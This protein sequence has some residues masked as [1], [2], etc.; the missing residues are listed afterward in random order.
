MFRRNK[1]F[2]MAT[3][4]DGSMANGQGTVPSYFIEEQTR[5]DVLEASRSFVPRVQRK[6]GVDLFAV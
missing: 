4:I 3:C 2:Q 1:P 5:K 6:H